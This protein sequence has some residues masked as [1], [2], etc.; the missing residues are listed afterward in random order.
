MLNVYKDLRPDAASSA[1]VGFGI[2]DW[3]FDPPKNRAD[4]SGNN[5]EVG[6]SDLTGAAR[7]VHRHVYG[8]VARLEARERQLLREQVASRRD[9]IGIESEARRADG[10]RAA[11]QHHFGAH[12]FWIGGGHFAGVPE[13]LGSGEDLIRARHQAEHAHIERT[14]APPGPRRREGEGRTRDARP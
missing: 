14:A 8:V 11:A 13:R 2:V 10:L 5:P 3:T 4:P 9:R 6:A 12:R 1:S 7:A